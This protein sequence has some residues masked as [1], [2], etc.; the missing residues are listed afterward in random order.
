MDWQQVSEQVTDLPSTFVRQAA[1][2]TQWLD[3][4]T[5]ALSLGAVGADGIDAAMSFSGA[6]YGWLDFWGLLFGFPRGSN[7]ADET[8]SAQIE[9]GLTSGAG[10]PSVIQTYILLV[11]G[12]NTIVADT[13]GTLGYTI[14]FTSQT[15]LAQINT[16]LN[17][18]SRVRPAGVPFTTYIMGAGP[19]LDTINFLDAPRVTGAYLSNGV[20]QVYPTLAAATPSASPLLPTLLLVD[21]TLNP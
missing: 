15:N 11:Y 3:A 5:A 6:A 17:G 7:E 9:F 13:P 10:S 20:I 1:P 16:V 2:F 21:P 19:Y 18:L 14:T 4:L 12:L 8:Y